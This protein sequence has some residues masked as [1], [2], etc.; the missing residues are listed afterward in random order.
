[1]YE[2]KTP[3]NRGIPV[4]VVGTLMVGFWSPHQAL[5]MQPP[6]EP[7]LPRCPSNWRLEVVMRAPQLCHPSVVCC[8]PDGRV[9]VAE[10]PMDISA[11]KAD[12]AR[13]RILCLHPGGRASIFAE[14]L[15]AVFG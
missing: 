1:R 6:G 8:A 4:F 13:G 9:F 5:G 15:H 10:D 2:M 12:M 7:T 11:P 14:G 3:S